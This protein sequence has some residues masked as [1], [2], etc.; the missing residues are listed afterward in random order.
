MK[1]IIEELYYGNI[2]PTELNNGESALKLKR[3]LGELA[4]IEQ[5]LTEAL[6]DKDKERFLR[7]MEQYNE[8][9][10]LSCADSFVTGFKLGAKFAC[11]MFT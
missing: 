8:F 2:E 6:T 1:S 11:E 4:K 5:E 9:S 7:C 3:K 10:G